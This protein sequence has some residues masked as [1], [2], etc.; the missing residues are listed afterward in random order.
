MDLFGRKRIADLEEALAD[1]ERLLNITQMGWAE[2]NKEIDKLEQSEL[3]LMGTIRNMDQL[4]YNMSQCTGFEGMRP[5]FNELLECTNKRMADESDR[6]KTA[7]IP[8][9][10]KAYRHPRASLPYRHYSSGEPRK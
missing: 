7:L 3:D 8:E 5:F 2:S 1:R 10:R 9:M 6:I 4:I